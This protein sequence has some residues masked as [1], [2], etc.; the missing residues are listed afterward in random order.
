MVEC[1]QAQLDAIFHALADGTRRAILRDLVGTEKSVSRIAEPYRMSL[2]AI[3]KH[4]K[5]LDA[6]QLIARRRAGASQLIRLN[7][8]VLRDAAHWLSFYRRFWT[9]RLDA[10]QLLLEDGDR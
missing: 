6:A 2:A 4:L 9:A 3:S 7:P 10:M 5:V 1:S 8:T